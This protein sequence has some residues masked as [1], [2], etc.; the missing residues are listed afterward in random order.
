MVDIKNKKIIILGATGRIG[1]YLA[2][3]FKEIG[4]D[5]I[6]CGHRKSDNG[7]FEDYDIPYIPLDIEKPNDFEKLPNE[8]V[9][10]VLDFAGM[11]PASMEGYNPDIYISS[12]IQG[13]LNVLEYCR[14][15]KVDRI[16]FPQ[17]LFD[18]SY[19]IG[20]RTPIPADAPRKAPMTGDHAMYVI[21][22]NTAVELIEHYY[23]AYGLKRFIFRLSRVY[24]Y[25]PD[26][27][28][29]KDG[30][31]ILISDRLL[32]Y[33]AIKGLP[34]ELWGDPNTLLETVNIY[35]FCN[36]IQ[37]S[38]ESETDGGF[39]NI[40]SGGTTLK[41]RIEGIID[42]FCPPD[43]KSEIVYVPL[44][45]PIREFV[46]DYSKTKEELGYEPSVSWKDYMRKFKDE[47]EQ[48]RFKKLWG[49]EQD[50]FNLN[51]IE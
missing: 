29:Y 30:K 23:H 28:A 45:K 5:V 3:H 13:T 49:L 50:H 20:S 1:A 47:M 16:I 12:I 48:Q 39:Y 40:G 34:I 4:C 36:I 41:E 33:R 25:L 32:I 42:V 19:L 7:F 22:K 38:L 10:A 6:A 2:L 15:T 44:T 46:L 37:K 26:P 35:D 9:Y 43:R 11:L 14:K 24:M 21:A 27:Y 51:D 8:G 18:I 17:S 31:K